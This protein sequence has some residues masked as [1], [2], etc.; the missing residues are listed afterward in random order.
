MS[1][2]TKSRCWPGY[3]PAP[4]K[5]PFANDSCIKAPQMRA[6]PGLKKGVSRKNLR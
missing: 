6:K 3:I 1:K 5:K 4:G 2:K